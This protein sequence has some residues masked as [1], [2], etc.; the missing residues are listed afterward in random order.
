MANRLL[1]KQT[2]FLNPGEVKGLILS[3]LYQTEL[4]NT[5]LNSL[6]ERTS[7]ATIYPLE[8]GPVSFNAEDGVTPGSDD[9]T[10]SP[11]DIL[12]VTTIED[13]RLLKIRNN[14]VSVAKLAV[15]YHGSA[16]QI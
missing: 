3:G 16:D 1:Y 2:L 15:H 7:Q 4:T 8:G 10:M 9:P 14:G 11:P 5:Q 6:K 13:I 12:D